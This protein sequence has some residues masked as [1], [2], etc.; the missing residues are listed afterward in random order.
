[1]SRAP[2][3]PSAH[4]GAFPSRLSR[5]TIVVAGAVLVACVTIAASVI[6][7]RPPHPTAA[8]QLLNVGA[9]QALLAGIPQK[10]VVLGQPDAP[11]RL[12]EFAD[13]QCPYCG[14]L[15]RVTLPTLIA[16]YVRSG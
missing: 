1:M 5:T 11:V 12:V 8:P 14:D 10:G 6:A 4:R 16:R 9:T 13:L 15:A 7:S 2:S 3:T